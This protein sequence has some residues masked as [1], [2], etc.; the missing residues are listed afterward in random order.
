MLIHWLS[1]APQPADSD[2][3]LRAVAG[4][5]ALVGFL[6]LAAPALGAPEGYAQRTGVYGLAFGVVAL[7]LGAIAWAAFAPAVAAE[8]AADRRR[9]VGAAAWLPALALARAGVLRRRRAASAS[10]SPPP[11]RALR[12]SPA[13]ASRVTRL[14]MLAVVVA[15]ALAT[16]RGLDRSAQGARLGAG[17]QSRIRF[18]AARRSALPNAAGPTQRCAR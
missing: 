4:V 3:L 12:C 17:A 10:T 8:R 16:D 9:I 15:V 6:P 14:T 2:A 1:I 7:T 13:A 5:F 11:M 18:A